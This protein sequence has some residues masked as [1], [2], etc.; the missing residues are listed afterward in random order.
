MS[1]FVTLVVGMTVRAPGVVPSTPISCK[2][3]DTVWVPATTALLFTKVP[4]K[5]YQTLVVRMAVAKL[6]AANPSMNELTANGLVPER[7]L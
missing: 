6:P 3:A 1:A 2:V 7:R 5:R 4:L